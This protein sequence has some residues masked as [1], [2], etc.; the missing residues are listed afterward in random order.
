MSRAHFRH[1]ERTISESR[2]HGSFCSILKATPTSRC[3]QYHK[4][5]ELF[6]TQLHSIDATLRTV[7]KSDLNIPS[8]SEVGAIKNIAAKDSFLNFLSNKIIRGERERSPPLPEIMQ[9]RFPH[10]GNSHGSAKHGV[11][12]LSLAVGEPTFLIMVSPLPGKYE[13]YMPVVEEGPHTRA[14]HT[15]GSYPSALAMPL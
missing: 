9:S 1:K 4:Q 14:S 15:D 6:N 5:F 10:L 2:T 13:L 11:Q 8:G 7:C 12:W 3:H